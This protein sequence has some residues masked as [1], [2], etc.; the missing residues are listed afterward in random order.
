MVLLALF[1]VL[2][3]VILLQGLTNDEAL[4]LRARS[5]LA[6]A[7]TFLIGAYIA[8]VNFSVTPLVMFGTIAQCNALASGGAQ[9]WLRDNL[10]LTAGAVT[11]AALKHPTIEI[12]PDQPISIIVLTAFFV[13]FSVF[14]YLAFTRNRALRSQL[15]ELE[16]RQIQLKL[17]NYSLSKYLSPT[18]YEAIASGRDVKLESQRKQLAIF[19]SD[20]QGFS[21]LAEEMD[22]DALAALLNNY[23]TEMSEIAIRYSATIDKFIGDAVMIF[24]G[25]PVSHGPKFDSVACVAMAIDMKKRMK[26]LQLRWLN[27]GIQKPL[28][29]R[30]GINTGYCTVGNFGTE[31]RL[32]YTALGTEVNLASRLESAAKPG[33]ILITHQTY[34]RWAY[35]WWSQSFWTVFAGC[36]TPAMAICA[37]GAANSRCST[38]TKPAMA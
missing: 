25:D 7:D 35:C 2:A 20:I 38:T 9:R 28:Q 13:Y 10:V 27:Q 36:A 19:F 33:E 4:L 15:S 29:I 32:D 21:E 18:L 17:R 24:F 1:Y 26:E 14:G 5:Y 6:D 22:A 12:R 11:V 30:M 23:L 8:F 16:E 31:N 3:S 34:C 37:W